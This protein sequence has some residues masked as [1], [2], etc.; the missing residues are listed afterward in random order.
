MKASD[1]VG[2]WLNQ[3]EKSLWDRPL[4]ESPLNARPLNASPLKAS[5]LNASPFSSSS[6]R[7]VHLG[8][9]RAR[10]DSSTGLHAVARVS[11]DAPRS[12]IFFMAFLLLLPTTVRA[13]GFSTEDSSR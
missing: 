1:S 9:L 13:R 10:A 2:C 6:A 8:S 12:S 5:P 4:N 7:A 11:R 3:E